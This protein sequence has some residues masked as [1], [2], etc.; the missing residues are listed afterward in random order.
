MFSFSYSLEY[1]LAFWVTF[2]GYGIIDLALLRNELGVIPRRHFVGQIVVGSICLI[3]G[4]YLCFAVWY[5]Y[6]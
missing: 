5:G 1:L 4:L 3:A 6:C 2:T